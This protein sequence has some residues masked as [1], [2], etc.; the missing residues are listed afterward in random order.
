M[1]RNRIDFS[2]S[3][4]I[5]GYVTNSPQEGKFALK[6]TDGREF[7]I[8]VSD[9]CYAEV[10]RNLGEP[11]QDAG[12][13]LAQL[14]PGRLVFAYGI[15]YPENGR[16]S[17]EAKHLVFAGKNADHY[18][19]E[20][21]DWWI[22]QICQLGEFYLEHQFDGG[23]IDYRNYRTD[24]TLEGQ[25][26][27]SIRQE[28]DTI[29][30]L[31][32]GFAS[33]YMLSGDERFLCA[34]EFGT[35]YLCDFFRRNDR[36]GEISYWNHALDIHPYGGAEPILPSQFGDDYGA[37]PAYEQ[38]YALAGPT[39][40][41][42]I[43]SDAKI[44][45]DIQKTIN[46]FNTCYHDP[47]SG[48]YFSHIDPLTFDPH[49]PSLGDNQSRKNWNS[50]GDHAPAYLINAVLA[51]GNR[52]WMTM[53]TQCTDC[54]VDHFQDYENS[55]FVNEK[56]HQDW[57][58]DHHWKWQQNRG[59]VG[60]NLKI[61]WNMTRLYCRTQTESYAQFAHTI[62]EKMPSCG[63]DTQRMGWYDVVNRTLAPEEK[64]HR[65]AWHDRKAWW[66]QEQGILAYL[67]MA[68][69]HK[70]TTYRR[71]AR[72]STAFYNAWFPDTSSGGVYFN[73]LSNGHPYPL[74]TERNKGSHSMSG[75]HS[76]EL[77]Y[78]AAV[79]TNLLITGNPL[80][81]FFK[82]NPK[83]LPGGCLNVS[84]DM[85]PGD[86]VKL[87]SVEVNGKSHQDFDGKNM[88]VRLAGNERVRVKAI[89]EPIS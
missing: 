3:D 62:A 36:G 24:L 61:A 56:F 72:E 33:A 80:T 82:P 18:V 53:L 11:Y 19:F 21:P 4:L 88:V 37:I 60:H 85:L 27:G 77:A 79:Y 43:T 14:Q 20:D 71:L 32:Y 87:T 73:V 68:G 89:L 40:T 78:L 7:Y 55:P 66:Q 52:D 49:A 25:K 84:P 26:T 28:A 1:D 9:N 50:V 48:G 30:R 44:F 13:L 22:R 5:S 42:R 58:P 83:S 39:Q 35:K 69:V 23:P 15:F 6:T 29:S 31:V 46:L 63:M 59:V 67:I 54:V 64:F 74:G 57:T 70:N 2:F 17:I 51:T 10:I 8:K 34:A 47:Q 81:L 76:F 41:Y 86:A 75:Y 65:F 45:E 16:V 38:I 12:D